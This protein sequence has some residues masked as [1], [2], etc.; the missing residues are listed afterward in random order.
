[1]RELESFGALWFQNKTC[2]CGGCG[3][4]GDL[5]WR[6]QFPL[7]R[8]CSQCLVRV[9]KTDGATKK[10]KGPPTAPSHHAGLA[11]TPSLSLRVGPVRRLDTLCPWDH[12]P[13]AGETNYCTGVVASK[14]F[15]D[16]I[17]HFCSQNETSLYKASCP[18][19]RHSFMRPLRSC[20]NTCDSETLLGPKSASATISPTFRVQI[21]AQQDCA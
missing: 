5:R 2:L 19:L 16:Q 14:D 6:R 17:A 12:D 18:L 13:N 8:I 9:S 11:M 7:L 20:K 21:C 4:A 3:F 15:L 10:Q 1:M